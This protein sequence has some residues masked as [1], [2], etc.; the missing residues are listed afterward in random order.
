MKYFLVVLLAL[1]GCASAPQPQPAAPKEDNTP[2]IIARGTDGNVD[3]VCNVENLNDKLVWIPCEFHAKEATSGA[4]ITVGFFD[5]TTGKPVEESR[6]FCSGPMQADEIK[7]NYAAFIQ[8]KRKGLQAC[9]EL[10]D[11]CVMLAGNA[12]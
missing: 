11:L 9:G 5:E 7:T 12:K 2:I 3:W 8:G 1:V 10:L 6:K 4:C